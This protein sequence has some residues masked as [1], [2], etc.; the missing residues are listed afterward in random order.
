MMSIPYLLIYNNNSKSK[1]MHV[2]LEQS[3]VDVAEKKNFNRQNIQ[4]CVNLRQLKEI[5]SEAE[6][7]PK[8]VILGHPQ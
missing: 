7:K 5:M 6:L 2:C 3:S 8:L 1:E 4:N